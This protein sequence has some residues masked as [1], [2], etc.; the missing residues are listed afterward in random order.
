MK[1][2][3][4]AAWRGHKFNS[5]DRGIEFHFSFEEWVKWWEDELGPDWFKKRGCR[6]GQFV[7]ARK[8]DKGPYAPWN[9]KCV[10]QA[11]NHAEYNARNGSKRRASRVMLCRAEIVGIY[12]SREKYKKIARIYEVPTGTIQRIKR[13]WSYGYIT[14]GLGPPG[15]HPR[16]PG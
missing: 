15:L 11:S 6:S 2:P 16:N 4:R 5:I 13:R 10:T 14:D 12:R 9:V 7:M 1:D 8:K 3:V